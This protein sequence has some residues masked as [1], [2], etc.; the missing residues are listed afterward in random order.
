[1]VWYRV[2]NACSL[3]CDADNLL[4]D[5]RL[6]II[7]SAALAVI[8]GLVTDGGLEYVSVALIGAITAILSLGKVTQRSDV[9]VGFIVGG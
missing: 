1:M 2:F 8:V 7:I 9:T 4:L 6:A 3:W 5:S